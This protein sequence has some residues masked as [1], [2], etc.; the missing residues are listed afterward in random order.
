MDEQEEKI[1]SGWVAFMKKIRNANITVESI[2][3]STI[4][5]SIFFQNGL[6]SKDLKEHLLKLANEYR[7][8]WQKHNES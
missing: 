8:E 3:V 4:I 5:C 2:V 7:V 1:D 6:K